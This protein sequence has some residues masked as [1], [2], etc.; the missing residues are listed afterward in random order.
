M[1]E[2][3]R[4]FGFNDL[5]MLEPLNYHEVPIAKGIS[6]KKLAQQLDVSYKD[7]K[8]LNPAYRGNFV[9]ILEVTLLFGFHSKKLKLASVAVENSSSRMPRQIAASYFYYRVRRGTIY[10]QSPIVMGLRYLILKDLTT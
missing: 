2:K 4:K 9:P 10:L 3:S 8:S 1:I 5:E 7:L 6:L